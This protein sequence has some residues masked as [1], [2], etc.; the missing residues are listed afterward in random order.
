MAKD[1]SGYVFQNQKGAWY[2]RTTITD[3][4]GKRRNIKRR[5]KD[6]KDAKSILKRMLKEIEEQALQ[7][8]DCLNRTFNDLADFYAANYCKPAEY[9]DGKKVT[10]LRDVQRAQSVLVRFRE[11][12]GKRL[13]KDTTYNDVRSYYLMRLKQKTHNKRPPTI[14]TM[15]RELG[16]LRRIFHIGV[17]EGWLSRNPFSTGEPLIS[18]ASERRRERILTLEEEKRLLEVCQRENLRTLYI[19][20]LDTGARLSELLKHLRWRSV[21]FASRTLTLEAM[22]TKTLKARQVGMTERVFQE[23]SALWKTSTKQPDARV[24]NATVRI[25]R[26]EFSLACKAAGIPYGSP[27]GITLH[28]LRHTAATRLVKGRM[29][30]QMVGRILGHSQPQTTYRYISSDN[31]ATAKAVEIFDSM[32]SQ[33]VATDAQQSE[34]VN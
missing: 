20:L 5:A 4:K 13:L 28:S 30:L 22:T 18:P 19:C 32:Q 3:A 6:K 16:V 27:N 12:F 34:L 23:L 10:G 21:C 29:P 25:A 7:S 15:N 11:Y 24:F 9:V 8:V 14:A 17:R 1:R 2:A 31:E 26:R 33:S